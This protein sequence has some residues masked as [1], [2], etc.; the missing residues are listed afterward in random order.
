M[1]KK[2]QQ[3]PRK[4]GPGRP[5][6]KGQC[7][8]PGGRPKDVGPVKDLARS[9]TQAAVERLAYWLSSNNARA[10]VAAAEALLDRGWGRPAQAITGEDG[11]P[12]LPTVVTHRIEVSALPVAVVSGPRLL[13]EFK[14]S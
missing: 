1:A 5:F 9:H 8:N 11:A 10:S 13:E 4:R 6:V 12:L 2:S 3:Q 7:P 14:E